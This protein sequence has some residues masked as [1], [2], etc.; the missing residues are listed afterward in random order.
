MNNK[1]YWDELSKKY[2]AMKAERQDEESHTP[3]SNDC[4]DDLYS[5]WQCCDTHKRLLAQHG[6]VQAIGVALG[7][8]YD[9][10]GPSSFDAGLS[11]HGIDSGVDYKSAQIGSQA[12]CE[13]LSEKSG[14]EI[15]QSIIDSWAWMDKK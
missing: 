14:A 6:Y 4:D 7:H 15:P 13:E 5:S 11:L 10:V 12:W 3:K 1:A 9:M 8:A 2:F